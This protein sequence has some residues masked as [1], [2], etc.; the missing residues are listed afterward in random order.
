M[1]ARDRPGVLAPPP[2]LFF[3]CL[4]LGWGL[5]FL[6][7]APL[8]FLGVGVRIAFG[9]FFFATGLLSAGSALITLHRAE[10]PA[11]PWKPTVRI[12][13]SG[14][15]RFTRNPIYVGLL[16]VLTGFAFFTPSLWIALSI[17]LLFLLLHFGVVRPE[18]K[19]LSEKFGEDYRDYLRRV[20][21]WI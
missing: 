3:A 14:P 15:Y 16:C 19:Y 4:L 20:R 21:R 12:V 10:T 17:G 9:I 2:I 18:E 6:A 8:S 1:P 7:P 13:S 11:E 5:D